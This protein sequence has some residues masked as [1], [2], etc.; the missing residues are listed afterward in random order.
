MA[1]SR[2]GRNDE[3]F[4]TV[5]IHVPRI[6]NRQFALHLQ[7]DSVGLFFNSCFQLSRSL[8]HL[9]FQLFNLNQMLRIERQ[10]WVVTIRLVCAEATVRSMLA[11][12]FHCRRKPKT[13]EIP[14]MIAQ[15]TN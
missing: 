9:A 3:N 7:R 4:G 10:R 2:V 13:L 14:V 5:R 15:V 8:L 1:T 6:A 11:T 12:L